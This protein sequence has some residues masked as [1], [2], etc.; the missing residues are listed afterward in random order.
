MK[1]RYPVEFK[2]SPRSTIDRFLLNLIKPLS[3]LMTHD[4]ETP[5]DPVDFVF[6]HLRGRLRGVDPPLRGQIL[7]KDIYLQFR[8]K[9]GALD[10]NEEVFCHSIQDLVDA[11]D[12]EN[13]LNRAL[14]ALFEMVVLPEAKSR[15]RG[16]AYA[17][18]NIFVHGVKFD[19]NG[20]RQLDIG[21]DGLREF[22]ELTMCE[23]TV[24][25]SN[26]QTPQK[27]RELEFYGQAFAKVR[28][29]VDE[30]T[31]LH[32]QVFA[33]DSRGL[34]LEELRQAEIEAIKR[35]RVSFHQMTYFS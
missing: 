3:D 12:T 22:N 13:N 6:R 15:F 5:V 11:I 25:L 26:F 32:F 14:G 10:R 31:K 20:I 17:P 8:T 19:H 18:A 23:C 9:G 16:T 21:I 4:D 34:E 24:T 33:A 1:S 27:V 29:C 28:E 35:S 30:E 7:V 2:E